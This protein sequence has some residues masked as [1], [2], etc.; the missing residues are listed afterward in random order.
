M[1]SPS[2]WRHSSVVE[3]TSIR[4]PW[5]CSSSGPVRLRPPTVRRARTS[6]PTTPWGTKLPRREAVVDAGTL[7]EVETAGQQTDVANHDTM[8]VAHHR[9]GAVDLN[10]DLVDRTGEVRYCGQRVGEP[11]EVVPSRALVCLR[12]GRVDAQPGHRHERLTVGVRHIYVQVQATKTSEQRAGQVGWHS[13]GPGNKFAVPRGTMARAMPLPARAW[14]QALT[15]PS[16]PT[17]NTSLSL[18]GPHRPRDGCSAPDRSRR[19]RS[20]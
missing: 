1:T 13:E 9:C 4:D 19:P 11:A 18:A 17:A 6:Q 7:E 10:G 2:S 14:A 16:P 3:L 8:S 15:V 20:P 12:H 5:K